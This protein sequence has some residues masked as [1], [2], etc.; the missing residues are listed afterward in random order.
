M[1][2]QGA[3]ENLKIL[4]VVIISLTL[5]FLPILFLV[6]ATDFFTI[7]KQLLIIG[8]V[9]ILLVV[10][11]V[12]I[13]IERKI[14]LTVH[15]LN[16][17]V[18]T[19]AVVLIVSTLLSRNRYDS[20][21][22]AVP[23]VF[24]ILFFFLIVNTIRDKRSFSFVLASLV[25][26]AAASSFITI[27]YFTNFYFLPIP[28]IKNQFFNTYGS[29]IQ[30][31]IYLIP[32]LIFSVFYI[33]K[34]VNFPKIMISQV[35]KT[36]VGFFIQL[37]AALACLAGVSLI[38]YQLI[39]LPNKPIVLPYIYGF[40]TALASISQDSSRFI[41]SLIFGSGYGTFLV[42][43]TR[44]KLPAFN[45]T[46]VWN[47]NFG[48]SSSYFLE[49]IATTGLA[50]AISFIAIIFSLLK[51][52][53]T[54]NP[55]FIPVIVMCILSIILP[56]SYVS[57][58]LLF[59]L[60]AIYVSY[61]NVSED[62][63]VSDMTLATVLTKNGM[64]SFE[65]TPE[66]KQESRS[67]SP[68]LPGI[69]F[70]L[71]ILISG[72]AGFYTY[73][74]AMSDFA[75]AES[76]KQARQNNGQKTYQLQAQAISDF[77]QRADYHRVFSQINL[78]VANSLSQGVQPGSSPSAQVQQN[79]V[80][81]L[82]QSINS[83]R[84]AVIISPLNSVH[85]QN[86]AQIY[87]ALINVGQ[88][89]EQFALSSMN[90]AIA[91]DPFNPQLYIQLGGIYYQLGNFDAAQNQFQVAINLKRDFANAYYNLGHALE[92]K[93]DFTNALATYRTVKQLSQGNQTNLDIINAKIEALEAK[94]GKT[95]INEQQVQAGSDQTPLE[96]STPSANLPPQKPPILIS[97][98][99]ERESAASPSGQ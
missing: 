19:F 54:K 67:E 17:P 21:I 1:E 12:K 71:V 55:F 81:L 98:P 4:S 33:A 6:N 2:K 95:T 78:A 27:A 41:L 84:N 20:L 47:L 8:S 18:L 92:Q 59:V 82:Q 10:W 28:E 30:H 61:L 13:L 85:W 31:L 79:I 40:Q 72:F 66:G 70:I 93:G 46:N 99:P 3:L 63:R 89:A 57:V 73:K 58:V 68:I 90:Q 9:V 49:L 36:D 35:I 39:F 32:I 22:Q 94:I 64:F 96:I 77:P 53:S 38:T 91:L 48:F 74:F 24:A 56:L 69:V 23:V 29:P 26:G 25:L 87:R 76:F 5:F 65:A 75:F 50:G 34:A 97:P 52:R 83:A 11:G 14:V 16:L 80:S 44:F 51:L 88:N 15:S 60:L 45:L 62:R 42:D 7:P 43:F 37:V 86:L